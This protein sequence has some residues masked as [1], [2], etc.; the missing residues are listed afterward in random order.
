MSKLDDWLTEMRAA[1]KIPGQTPGAEAAW[2]LLAETL[3]AR[4]P[5]S[6]GAQGLIS[7]D[8]SGS[9]FQESLSAGVTLDDH[10]WAVKVLT[11]LVAALGINPK[12]LED[13]SWA[14]KTHKSKAFNQQQRAEP[15]R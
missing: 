14:A 11:S 2:D 1:G 4:A 9:L 6:Y 10:V 8:E 13:V 5:V 3:E 15:M 7:E 12:R